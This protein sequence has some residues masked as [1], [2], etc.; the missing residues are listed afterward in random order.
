[1]ADAVLTILQR[2]ARQPPE[3]GPNDRFYQCAVAYECAKRLDDASGHGEKA[4]ALLDAMIDDIS[5]SAEVTRRRGPRR[6]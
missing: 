3:H 5:K 6:F 1:M 4:R 2:I